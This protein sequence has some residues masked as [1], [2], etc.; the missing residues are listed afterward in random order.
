MHMTANPVALVVVAIGALVAGVVVA[1]INL[2]RSAL[3]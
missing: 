1:I 3:Q 2:I